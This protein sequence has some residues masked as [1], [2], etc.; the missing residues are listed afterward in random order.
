MS[1]FKSGE[2][3]LHDFTSARNI[4]AERLMQLN[5][6]LKI[7][8]DVVKSMKS[9]IHNLKKSRLCKKNL[10]EI[11]TIL[12][13]LKINKRAYINYKHDIFKAFSQLCA[14]DRII[15]KLSN[16]D[17]EYIEGDMSEPLTNSYTEN[18]FETI[19]RNDLLNIIKNISTT[20]SD[21]TN[22]LKNAPESNQFDIKSEIVKT[23][24]T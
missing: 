4:W 3:S 22:L 2:V 13:Q 24:K 18:G 20:L 17:F 6:M 19:T 5:N 11:A 16:N 12:D 23:F 15:N 8:K 10:T 9:R 1:E 21:L 7:N 14:I